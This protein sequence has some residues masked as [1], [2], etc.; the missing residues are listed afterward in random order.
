MNSLLEI[1]PRADESK[2]PLASKSLPILFESLLE[3]PANAELVRPPD[4]KDG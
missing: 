4:P 2:V 1:K 3:I